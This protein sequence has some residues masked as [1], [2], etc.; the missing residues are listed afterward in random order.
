MQYIKTFQTT[1]AIQILLF[2]FVDCRILGKIV[3]KL[4]RCL[5]MSL[6]ME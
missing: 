3:E 5:F 6:G 2:L 4:A 1:I